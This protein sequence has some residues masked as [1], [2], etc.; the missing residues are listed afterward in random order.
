MRTIHLAT[1]VACASLSTGVAGVTIWQ[2]YAGTTERITAA[3]IGLAI[4]WTVRAVWR[5][6]GPSDKGIVL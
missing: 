5:E 4:V 3:I 2:G 1:L 6:S